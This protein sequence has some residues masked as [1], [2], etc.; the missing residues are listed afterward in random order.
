M[1]ELCKA[2][3][4]QHQ[5]ISWQ[6][7]IAYALNELDLQYVI[8]DVEKRLLF[9]TDDIE[10]PTLDTFNVDDLL[11]VW[12]VPTVDTRIH[13]NPCSHTFI[14]EEVFENR[15]LAQLSAEDERARHSSVAP[16]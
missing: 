10:H 5:W 7:G 4:Y 1:E 2:H 12:G 13:L 8:G 16:R 3:G 15:F 6:A 14:E 11:D 9:W